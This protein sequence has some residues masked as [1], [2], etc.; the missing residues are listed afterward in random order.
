MRADPWYLRNKSPYYLSY[1]TKISQYNI[2]VTYH[3]TQLTE[4][5]HN[6]ETHESLLYKPQKLFF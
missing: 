6:L 5:S 2:S 3:K 4:K 1:M